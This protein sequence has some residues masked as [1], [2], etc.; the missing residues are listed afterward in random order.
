[1]CLGMGLAYMGAFVTPEPNDMP[2][3]VVGSG[4]QAKVLAQTVEDKAGD[5]L[6]V[7]TLPDREHAVDALSPWTS[8]GPSCPTPRRPS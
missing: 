8:P 7:R 4:P 6:D 2:V 3:A 1:M 5:A